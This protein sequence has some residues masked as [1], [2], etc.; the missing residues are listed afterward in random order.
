M[1]RSR[2]EFCWVDCTPYT[3]I[4]LEDSPVPKKPTMFEAAKRVM[5]IMESITAREIIV[6]L[7]DGGRKELPTPRQLAQ[8]FR[9]D[10]EIESIRSDKNKEPTI[11]RRIR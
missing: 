1:G 7:K 11:F 2:D 3:V 9:S 4:F 10:P 6:R 5:G 8:K